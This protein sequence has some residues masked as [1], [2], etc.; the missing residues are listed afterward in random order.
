MYIATYVYS[1]YNYTDCNNNLDTTM[2]LM[3]AI[4][5]YLTATK[6]LYKDHGY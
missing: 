1:I 2:A 6:P 4:A 5:V 3:T